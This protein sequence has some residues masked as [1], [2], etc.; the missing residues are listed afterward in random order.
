MYPKVHPK[1]LSKLRILCYFSNTWLKIWRKSWWSCL[2]WYI[3]SVLHTFPL[4]CCLLLFGRNSP[5]VHSWRKI[6][7][8]KQHF[9]FFFPEILQIVFACYKLLSESFFAVISSQNLKIYMKIASN[10]WLEIAPWEI[11]LPF[12]I[13]KNTK[14]A[15]LVLSMN[16]S[17]D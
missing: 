7:F 3:R 10:A 1:L 2:F 12:K 15:D 17:Y 5:A 16:S 8:M 9:Y 4:S 6:V 11:S 14:I 13:M